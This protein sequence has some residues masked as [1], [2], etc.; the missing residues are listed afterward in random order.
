MKKK[1][2]VGRGSVKLTGEPQLRDHLR[3]FCVNF[4]SS[5]M[6]PPTVWPII[7]RGIQGHE[8]GDSL[9]QDNFLKMSSWSNN[10]VYLSCL[11]T[12]IIILILSCPLSHQAPCR[13]NGSYFRQFYTTMKFLKTWWF[14]YTWYIAQ[15][16]ST[17]YSF[18][19]TFC[20]AQCETSCAYNSAV[21]AISQQLNETDTHS[22]WCTCSRPPRT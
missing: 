15:M 14:L 13:N 10:S 1:Y 21:R 9:C 6:F 2:F 5:W 7:P 11:V 18:C 8:I 19:L 22:N 20:L 17:F 12:N 4:G 16:C 3:N